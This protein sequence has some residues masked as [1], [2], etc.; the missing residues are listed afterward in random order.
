M[1][2]NIFKNIDKNSDKKTI[3]LTEKDMKEA[4]NKKVVKDIWKYVKIR[5]EMGIFQPIE[6]T[7]VYSLD[8]YIG[9][10]MPRD[11][12][13]GL[14]GKEICA[15]KDDYIVFDF[16]RNV[17]YVKAEDFSSFYKYSV[18]SEYQ[19]LLSAIQ[20]FKIETSAD[21]IFIKS[22][23]NKS[24]HNSEDAVFDKLA[25]MIMNGNVKDEYIDAYRSIMEE[26][27]KNELINYTVLSDFKAQYIV[28]KLKEKK[29]P[30]ALISPLV[31]SI[32][33]IDDDDEFDVDKIIAFNDFMAMI[34]TAAAYAEDLKD[35]IEET[36]QELFG[37]SHS[38]D[39]LSLDELVAF[40]AQFETA[41]MPIPGINIE[42]IV[43][44]MKQE[45]MEE[46]QV[47]G[48]DDIAKDTDDLF[49]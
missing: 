36:N 1:K 46:F 18:V 43:E 42:K 5:I 17:S 30:F 34:V 44:Q 4:Q 29:V 27:Y 13:I 9:I 28:R 49:L 8:V 40:K 20:L 11:L 48:N 45:S 37:K 33:E 21:E 14:D 3:Q 12:Y 19:Q 23:Y 24:F 7:D 22:N 2:D 41:G 32:V 38:I 6:L 10:K 39:T 15:R 26:K 31:D 25:E 16:N 47:Y 35:C